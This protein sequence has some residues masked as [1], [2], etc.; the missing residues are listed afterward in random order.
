MKIKLLLIISICITASCTTPKKNPKKSKLQNIIDERIAEIELGRNM[1]GRLLQFYGSY[2]NEKLLKYINTV[3]LHVAKFSDDPER[4]FFFELLDTDIINAFACPGGYILITKG[5]LKNIKD[6][7]ELA[8][9][10]GHEIA[11]VTKKHLFNTIIKQ[12]K[13]GISKKTT[14]KMSHKKDSQIFSR[15]R[16]EQTE[17]SHAGQ[18]FARY[19]SGATGLS[20]SL[21]K[22]AK[23][24]IDIILSKGLAKSLEYE[25]DSVGVQYAVRAGYSPFALKKFL[26]RIANKNK[27]K[28]LELI[29]KTHPKPQMRQK[30]LTML[31]KKIDAKKIVGAKGKKRYSKAKKLLK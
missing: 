28:N 22:A 9:I 17:K 31:L 24:G 18:V 12:Q 20:V 14:Q 26:K 7:S 3:G 11:H 8:A 27:K 30:K 16:I 25:A 13:D 10:L 1:A 15:T 2:K 21:L 19:F 23:Q 4:R 6:E 29:T 5:T